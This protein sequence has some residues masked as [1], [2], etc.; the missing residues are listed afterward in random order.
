M[1]DQ[2][3]KMKSPL[4]FLLSASLLL[5]A[6][7][8]GVGQSPAPTSSS[9]R[10]DRPLVGH[11]TDSPVEGLTYM[12]ESQSGI[13]D[14]SGAF[15]YKEGETIQFSIGNL[16][17]GARVDAVEEMTPVDLI[18][19]VVLPTTTS[20]V[21]N[22]FEQIYQTPAPPEALAFNKLHNMVTF[23]QALDSDKD[24]SNGITIAAGIGTLLNAEIDVE[25]ISL[26]FDK[27]YYSFRSDS[28]LKRVLMA[29]QSQNLV[30]S[31][32]VPLPGRALD[33]FYDAQGIS[34]SIVL[35]GTTSYDTNGDGIADSIY[36]YTYDSNG[37]RLT[38]SSDT[39]GDGTAESIYTYTHD[40]N[41]NLLTN[42]YDSNGDGTAN[43]IGTYTY[44]SN[45]N[46]LTSS[47]DTNGDG[48]AE[49]I[50]TYT[51]DSNGNQLTFS[52]DGNAD[53]IADSIS[54]YTYDSNGNQLTSSNDSNADGIT[55][56]ITTYTYVP[57]SFMGWLLSQ[58]D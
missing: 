53:G 48:T 52:Y 33:H 16:L 10:P 57:G 19:G 43:Y 50:Y 40:S 8:G 44:D 35:Q 6:C 24:A 54:S 46:Q 4:V 28:L 42:S 49:S 13:T 32:F 15:K 51:Y 39:N 34:H 25:G 56:R 3:L 12:T 22:L 14:A 26:D 27:D 23:L 38:V 17:L 18:P 20:K 45:G 31:A 36:T 55:D 7:G 1:T 30:D 41:G 21:E 58:F 11:F 9:P 2:K 47:Y 5:T 29:A 37:N